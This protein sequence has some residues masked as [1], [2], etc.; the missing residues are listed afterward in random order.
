MKIRKTAV[1]GRFYPD[2]PDKIKQLLAG[3]LL[4]EKDNIDFS[5]AEKEIIG[6]VLP[7]AGYMFSAYQA[8]HFLKYFSVPLRFLTLLLSST[9]TMP[10]MAL[11]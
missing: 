8:V 11:K 5:L 6:A 4:K 3:I 7:H 2:S 10:G 1:A 9:R